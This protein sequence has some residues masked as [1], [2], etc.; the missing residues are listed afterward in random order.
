[1]PTTPASPAPLPSP[2]SPPA[3]AF[4]SAYERALALWPVAAERLDLEGEF[5]TTR[6]TACGP[7][8]APPLV[9]LGS[10]GTASPGWYARVAALART[11]RVCAVDVLGAPGLSVPG[12][13]PLRRPPEL[14]AWLDGVLDGLGADRAALLGHS[15]GGWIALSYAVHAPDRVA[16]LALLDPT[17]CFAGY[18]ASYLVRAAP[19]F[20]RPGAASARRFLAWESRGGPAVAPELVGLMGAGGR[21]FRG[22]PVTGPRPAAARLGSAAPPALVVLAGRSRAHDVA[23]VAESARRALPGVRLA[24]PADCGHHVLPEL[25]SAELDRRLGNFLADGADGA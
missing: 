9:L 25:R 24:A 6:V 21:A 4:R 20:V 14:M 18:R 5:G 22:R 10:G 7:T 2:G 3:R 16:R 1:M 11:H 15:Y 17:Q 8:G 19:L 12:G 13:R 23:R